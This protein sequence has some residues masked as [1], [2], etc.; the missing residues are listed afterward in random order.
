MAISC[1]RR[2]G[3]RSNDDDLSS[4][5]RY[6]GRLRAYNISSWASNSSLC[7]RHLGARLATTQQRRRA[8]T[9]MPMVS[10]KILSL[11][12]SLSLFSLLSFSFLLLFRFLSFVIIAPPARNLSPHGHV[13]SLCVFTVWKVSTKA[14]RASRKYCVARPSSVWCGGRRRQKA[15]W[16]IYGVLVTAVAASTR[17]CRYHFPDLAPTSKRRTNN[18]GLAC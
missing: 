2:I 10:S 16:W 11:S 6:K 15:R 5:D 7:L 9:T 3:G 8:A 4:L 13:P 18:P 17:A 14:L 12:F 1:G